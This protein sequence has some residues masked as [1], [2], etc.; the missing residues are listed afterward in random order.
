MSSDPEALGT[1]EAGRSAGGRRQ[2]DRQLAVIGRGWEL[3]SRTQGGVSMRGLALAIPCILIVTGLSGC[4]RRTEALQVTE[5]VLGPAPDHPRAGPDRSWPVSRANGGRLACTTQVGPRWCLVLDG[6]KGPE[7]DAIAEP[8][9]TLSPDGQRLAY[10]AR[11]G[12]Q[13]FVVL[14]GEEGPRHD[15]GGDTTI[16]FSRDGRRVAYA[17]KKAEQW[18]M[19]VDRQEGPGYDQVQHPTF[20]ADGRRM[21]FE[22]RRGEKWFVVVDHQEGPGYEQVQQPTF[23][24]DGQ[25]VAYEARKGQEWSMVVDGEEGPGYDR[26]LEATFS[27]DGRRVAY[28][29]NRGE[30]SFVV[31]DGEEDRGYPSVDSLTFSPDGRRVGYRAKLPRETWIVVVDGE[32][33]TRT[34]E[35]WIEVV[36]KKVVEDADF[37]S[38]IRG[39]VKGTGS[40]KYVVLD[41]RRR[42]PEYDDIAPGFWY[43]PDGKRVAYVAR[44]GEDWLMVVDGKEGRAYDHFGPP[45]FSRNGRRMAYLAV[46]YGERPG[47]GVLDVHEVGGL[48]SYNWVVCGV[49]GPLYYAR[50]A[51][52]SP[53]EYWVVVVDGQEGPRYQHI[54][55]GTISNSDAAVTYLAARDHQLIRVTHRAARAGAAR[56]GTPR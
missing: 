2:T 41:G 11:R 24:S 56:H 50:E 19:V 13:W 36:D 55:K 8:S 14:D 32:P 26:V 51:P 53:G 21:A 33:I 16:T 10:E 25:R 1:H 4:A 22:A 3:A 49:E 9:M 43:T 34:R 45:I 31:V 28:M 42:G 23:S 18:F 35:R 48:Q 47:P 39:S 7:Y 40:R 5:E 44:K 20:S 27:P 17:A 30:E 37:V 15:Y 52:M 29:A 6:Q 12:R 38:P 54:W 46:E